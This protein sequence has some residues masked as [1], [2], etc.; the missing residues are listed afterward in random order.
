MKT[1]SAHLLTKLGDRLGFK[2]IPADAVANIIQQIDGAVRHGRPISGYQPFANRKM[3]SA[4]VQFF[5]MDGL[6]EIWVTKDIFI[7]TSPDT[8]QLI[9]IYPADFLTNAVRGKAT[10][11]RHKRYATA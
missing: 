9:T 1:I 4:K 5:A 7:L 8:T 2:N 10:N 3:F 6:K 11:E